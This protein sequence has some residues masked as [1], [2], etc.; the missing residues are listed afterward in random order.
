[1]NEL[2]NLDN[3]PVFSWF[4]ILFHYLIALIISWS[5]ILL[6]NNDPI[7]SKVFKPLILHVSM[8]IPSIG[9]YAA[10]CPNPDRVRLY[11]LLC[12]LGTPFYIRFF[13][14]LSAFVL[15]AWVRA[16]RTFH[17]W[18]ISVFSLVLAISVLMLP[19][20][21]FSIK[22]VGE[23]YGQTAWLLLLIRDSYIFFSIMGIVYVL[24]FSFMV[25]TSLKSIQ[26]RLSY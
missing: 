13:W 7:L 26:I 14:K 23:S 1:M 15:P 22:T 17:F 5:G 11:L 21:H 10:I 19:T 6:I 8:L 4:P 18:L 20:V 25:A 12:W 3:R 24:T 16:Q 9:G 2:N